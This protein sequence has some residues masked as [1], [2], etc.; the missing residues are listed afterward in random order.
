MTMG[1]TQLCV[2]VAVFS[3]WCG[4]V[5]AENA[6]AQMPTGSGDAAAQMPASA[7]APTDPTSTAPDTRA[8]SSRETGDIV[9]TA[10]RRAENLSKVPI[11]ITAF[12]GEALAR[13]SIRSESD[14]Q[15]ATPGLLVRETGSNNVFSYAIRGQSIDAYSN[16]APAVIPY[17]DDVYVKSYST[18]AF[19]DLSSVQ[20]LKGPQ[21]TLF[22]RN[23]TGGAILYHT[24]DP[25]G[26]GD[27]GFLYARGGNLDTYQI[28][29]AVTARL[30]D[31]LS[32]RLAGNHT[33]DGGYIHNIFNNEMDGGNTDNSVRGTLRAVIS[34]SLKTTTTVQYSHDDG[35]NAPATLYSINP[36]GSSADTPPRF[37]VTACL[38]SPA[39][40][41][42][43]AYVASN[44]ALF[45]GG[46][47]A[48]VN[49]Q[50]NVLG[51]WGASIDSE[52]NH[53]A[54]TVLA[55]NTTEAALSPT[56]SL[57]NIAGW[58]RSAKHDNYD[59]DGT[60]YGIFANVPGDN[61]QVQQTT[62][63]SEELQLQGKVL[64]DSLTFTLGG[65]YSKETD[66][67]QSADYVFDFYPLAP[68]PAP[69][70]YRF[71][72]SDVSLAGFFQATYN[73]TDAL[74]L[75]GG[76]RYSSDKLVAQN[77]PG[78]LYYALPGTL[79]IQRRTDAKPSWTAG[80]DDQITPSLE[81]ADRRVQFHGATH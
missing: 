78:S 10:R 17:I 68:H 29:G 57:K 44:P 50:K 11:A 43:Q 20:V 24:Q 74:H 1:R 35:K 81:L 48:Y 12:S 60:S 28:T 69:T 13:Q 30:S 59:F 56:L 4:P 75:T 63:Y 21:G 23:T 54:Y 70:V 47:A 26:S 38:F 64:H 7:S 72:V 55:I 14:L 6:L 66:Y 32:L 15:A 53:N 37:D 18:S 31:N 79:P 77:L 33:R 41:T 40:P 45:P 71:D 61:A 5:L 27:Q 46:L 9:V 51:I 36:C 34:P 73:L 3:A 76:F 22:G 16:S 39:N 58:S 67:T 19:Y 25:S 65:F 49:Y 80:I 2:G 52:L 42:F 62:Q 8:A